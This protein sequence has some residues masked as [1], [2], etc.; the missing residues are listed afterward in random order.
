M[1]GRMSRGFSHAGIE[2]LGSEKLRPMTLPPPPVG[3]VCVTELG[4]SVTTVE[5]V[6][7]F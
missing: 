7:L 1:S 4:G 2:P 3:L 5:D 6:I